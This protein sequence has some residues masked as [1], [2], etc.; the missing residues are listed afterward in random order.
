M[1]TQTDV[2]R[3]KIAKILN[4][5]EIALNVGGQDGVET[6]MLFDILYQ[7]GLGINDPDTGEE[8]G[9]VDLPK[10]RVKITRVY[11]RL[12]VAST[13][14]SNRVNTGGVDLGVHSLFQPP[15][16]ET[17]YETLKLEGPL[18]RSSEDS[19]EQDSYVS[20]GDPV[21]QVVQVFDDDE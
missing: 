16:W 3:G 9:S 19:D 12:S 10:Q 8:L 20:I 6:G 7:K 21:V 18:E 14:R 1:A 13:Y 5:R 15:R 4:S 17:R 2:I 11:D